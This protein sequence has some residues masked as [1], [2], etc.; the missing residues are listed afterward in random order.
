LKSPRAASPQPDRVRD[1]RLLTERWLKVCGGKS[2]LSIGVFAEAD[3]YPLIVV[4]SE[5]FDPEKPSLYLSAGIHGDEP[6]P[7]EALIRWAE[8]N[9]AGLGSWNLLIFPCLNPWGLERNIRFDAKGRDLNRCYNSRK[10]SRITAQLSLMKGRRFDIAAC[11]HEDYDARGFYL[12]EIAAARPHLGEGICRELSRVMP[13]DDR[14]MIDG[15]RARGGLIRRRIRPEMLPGHPEAF[16]LHFHHADRTFTL[17]SPSEESLKQR[18]LLQG[19]FLKC[20]NKKFKTRD[21]KEVET[22]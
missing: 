21:G 16:L 9:K 20:L 3:G 12:Y 13:A 19:E 17:E 11:L 14:S 7:V 4:E 8:K 1:Y 2:G 6:A 10:L 18:I 15:H 22:R 5:S